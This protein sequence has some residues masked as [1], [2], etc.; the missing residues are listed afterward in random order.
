[1]HGS[2]THKRLSDCH[3]GNRRRHALGWMTTQAG[4]RR[5]TRLASFFFVA[6]NKISFSELCDKNDL[7]LLEKGRIEGNSAKH[8]IQ[9]ITVL[10]T[11]RGSEAPPLG[12]TAHAPLN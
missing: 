3:L 1:M 9:L 6:T 8:R 11:R 2:T 10:S 7:V 4:S 12:T 5:L